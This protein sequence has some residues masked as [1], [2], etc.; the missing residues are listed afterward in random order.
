MEKI[1]ISES[2][3]RQA[4]ENIDCSRERKSTLW[5]EYRSGRLDDV[6]SILIDKNVATDAVS[7]AMHLLEG[8]NNKKAVLKIKLSD[9]DNTSS[10][11]AL[12][13]VLGERLG[14]QDKNKSAGDPSRVFGI[15]SHVTIPA[16][17]CGEI[18]KDTK[19]GR[20]GVNNDPEQMTFSFI[21]DVQQNIP[22]TLFPIKITAKKS[23][24]KQIS[25]ERKMEKIESYWNAVVESMK[26]VRF[27][28]RTKNYEKLVELMRSIFQKDLEDILKLGKKTPENAYLAFITV[29]S[30]ATA[31]IQH[32]NEDSKVLF[33]EISLLPHRF[34]VGLGRIDALEVETIDGKIPSRAQLKILRHLSKQGIKSVGHLIREFIRHF[35]YNISLV[36]HDWKFCAGDG[37]NGINKTLNLIHTESILEKPLLKHLRQMERYNSGSLISYAMVIDETISNLSDV[38]SKNHF[39]ISGKIHYFQPNVP[40]IVHTVILDE[41]QKKEVFREQVVQ[42]YTDAEKRSQIVSIGKEWLQYSIALLGGDSFTK[43][44]GSHQLELDLGKS[45]E[46][47]ISKLIKDAI[48]RRWYDQLEIVEYLGEEK[49][50]EPKLRMY[51]SKLRESIDSGLIP[52]GKNYDHAT[53]GHV[54]CFLPNHGHTGKG[55]PSLYINRSKRFF[56]CY[57]SCGAWGYLATDESDDSVRPL[58]SINRRLAVRS[59]GDIQSFRVPDRYTEAMQA[60]QH[61]FQNQFLDSLG[62]RYLEDVRKLNPELSMKI[63]A[64][65]ADQRSIEYMFDMGFS[66]D[67]LIEFGFVGISHN[68]K[69]IGPTSKMVQLLKHRGLTLDQIQRSKAKTID[70]ATAEILKQKGFT[71][72]EAQLLGLNTSGK[73]QAVIQ[74]A[75]PYIVLDNRLTYP[76]DVGHVITHFYGRSVDPKCPK[77]YAHQKTSPQGDIPQGGFNI[78]SS[79]EKAIQKV[80]DKPGIFPEIGMTEAPVDADTNFQKG[81]LKEFGAFV[82]VNNRLLFQILGCFPGSLNIG[83]NWD[84]SKIV[85]GVEALMAGQKNTVKIVKFLQSINF[86]F[87]VYDVTEPLAKRIP[88]FNDFNGHWQKVYENYWGTNPAGKNE[89]SLRD[90]LNPFDVLYNKKRIL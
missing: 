76:L 43:E 52:V 35:G 69:E 49:S 15:K 11:K 2:D 10:N 78:T 42:N 77:D 50:G 90:Y 81:D 62:A 41:E 19:R 38:W 4:C 26:T 83:L 44:H 40:P 9:L 1:T 65:F 27:P 31:L 29:M 25:F 7:A 86:A 58:T 17:F 85:D 79:M 3:I 89:G 6:V 71:F 70:S 39:S 5:N 54:M 23:L 13:K 80:K 60:A 66:Y 57:G 22:L 37:D 75:L 8:Q 47:K 16:L 32:N 84:D 74:G 36:I 28:V 64:G 30:W 24:S 48:E 55:T 61:I 59:F 72:N 53:G 68:V 63:G 18:L 21:S 14:K 87:P 20:R 34:D 82:G 51:E 45:H 88:G 56:K 12:Y 67:E 46:G 73:T 33:R